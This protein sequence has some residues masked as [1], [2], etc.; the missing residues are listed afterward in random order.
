MAAFRQADILEP[1][2]V[3]AERI[4]DGAS[5]VRVFIAVEHQDRGVDRIEDRRL[6]VVA[7]ETQDVAQP[8]GGLR[9]SSDV[10]RLSRTWAVE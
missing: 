8:R 1:P 2:D 9:P 4:P 5:R 3:R 6:D 10:A 7:L